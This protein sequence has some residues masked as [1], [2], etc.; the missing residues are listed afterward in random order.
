MIAK[1]SSAHPS[2]GPRAQVHLL[3]RR[4]QL[5]AASRRSITCTC[6]I[7]SNA[8]C[9]SAAPINGG[10]SRMGIDLN[11]TA[12]L[13]DGLRA[14]LAARR[15]SGRDQVRQER[16]GCHPGC[17]AQRTRPY[18]HVAVPLQQRRHARPATC[19]V[20]STLLDD[21]EIE[22]LEELTQAHP[23]RREA[24]RA[25][26]G[27]VTALVHG[28]AEAARA[29]DGGR[30]PFTV[31]RSPS[32]T[33]RPCSTCSPKPPRRSSR[34]RTSTPASWW[35]TRWPGRTSC[36]PRARPGAPSSRAAPTST[37]PRLH[38]PRRRRIRAPAPAPRPVQQVLQRSRKDHH[39]L[40]FG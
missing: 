32:S 11:P 19:C 2:A 12:A 31:R 4:V 24:Q 14:D 36:P 1:E 18:R 38:R 39:L 29:G 8:G 28:G 25:L 10:T 22:V 13:R 9:R 40:R 30:M 20:G 34:A 23:E 21:A 35:R 3:H 37:T 26:A 16:I 17:P 33:S 27:A 6:S 15:Q 7:P 5:H